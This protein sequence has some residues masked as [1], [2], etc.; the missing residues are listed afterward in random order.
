MANGP[1]PEAASPTLAIWALPLHASTEKRN[2]SSGE[3]PAAMALT[4]YAMPNGATPAM[5][6]AAARAPRDI[7]APSA[8]EAVREASLPSALTPRPRG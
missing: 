7:S 3:N 5:N 6:G 4:A 8:G 2:V 1:E